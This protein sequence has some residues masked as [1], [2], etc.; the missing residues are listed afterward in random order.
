MRK[1][2]ERR[3]AVYRASSSNCSRP[4]GDID[5]ALRLENEADACCMHQ[6]S[7][8]KA[9]AARAE[10]KA[11]HVEQQL[12]DV[13]LQLHA[14]HEEHTGSSL[15]A[16]RR[17]I[18]SLQKEAQQG[19]TIDSQAKGALAQLQGKWES[20]QHRQLDLQLELDLKMQKPLMAAL[21]GVRSQ[22]PAVWI[23]F[24]TS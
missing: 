10:H 18:D 7:K 6:A 14:T 8:L 12:C 5:P 22:K 1:A 23:H 3:R 16:A 11:L 19:H 2:G 9:D 13:T 21:T 20:L 24:I 4:R 15:T 17:E